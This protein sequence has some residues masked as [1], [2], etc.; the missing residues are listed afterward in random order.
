MPGLD[1]STAGT[2]AGL[3]ASATWLQYAITSDRTFHDGNKMWC[4][5]VEHVDAGIWRLLEEEGRRIDVDDGS[6][7]LLRDGMRSA[8][9]CTDNESSTEARERRRKSSKSVITDW[10]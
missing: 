7:G 10:D 4:L 1:P 3:G 9:R 8:L 6:N 5:N 2:V